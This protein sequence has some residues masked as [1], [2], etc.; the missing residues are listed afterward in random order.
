MLAVIALSALTVAAP[1]AAKVESAAEAKVRVLS[2]VT[3]SKSG[4]GKSSSPHKKEILVKERGG[5]LT[6]VRIVEYE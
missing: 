1:L 5:Q 4:W 2:A 3:A 6:L